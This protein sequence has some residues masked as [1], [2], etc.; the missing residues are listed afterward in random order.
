MILQRAK[1]S[2]K[3]FGCQ[4]NKADSE[5]IAGRMEA[6]GLERAAN[7]KLADLVFLVTCGVRQSAEDR[8]YGVANQIRKDNPKAKIILTGCLV[9]REEVKKRLDEKVDFWMNISEIFNFQFSTIRGHAIFKQFLIS[10]K[11]PNSKFQIPNKSQNSKSQINNCK[12]LEITP[13]HTSN[14]SAFVPIGNGCDNF[15]SY[16]VV[17][18]ARGR[19]VYR[20]AEEIINEVKSLIKKRYKEITLIAQN[21]NSYKSKKQK[22][23]KT[24]KQKKENIDFADLLRLVNDISGEFWIRFATSH[25]KDMS[26]KLIKTVAECEKVCKHIHLPVQAGSDN[27]LRKMNRRYTRGKYI[28]LINKIKAITKF[29]IPNSKFQIP[30]SITTDIIVGFPGETKKDFEDTKKLFKKVK[31]DMAYIARYSPRPGTAAYKLMDNVSKDEK[32]RRDEEL[33]R[34]LRIT[35]LENNK[36]YIGRVVKV[37]VES[38]NKKG[39]WVGRTETNKVAMLKIKNKKEQNL[40]GIFRFAMINKVSDFGLEGELI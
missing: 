4:M 28:K 5:R 10:N 11:I 2:L 32:K 38:K 13:K 17:P 25:P 39:E 8:I 14:F 27:V 24:K 9:G 19:E 37:L 15:C 40:V 35:A 7:H 16:C 33:N 12:Y 23:K 31:Y 3:A 30:V 6:L 20:P 18:Y 29:Q 1:Y 22:N 36:K 26:D 21:V 34:I